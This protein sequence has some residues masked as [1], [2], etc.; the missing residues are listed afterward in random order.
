V[1]VE[2]GIHHAHNPVER[3]RPVIPDDRMP[4]RLVEVVRE[5]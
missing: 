3:G 1:S 4:L 2:G 5:I